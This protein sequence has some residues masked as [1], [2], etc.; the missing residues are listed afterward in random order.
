ML[1]P[2][3]LQV[4]AN[5]CV[6]R[7]ENATIYDGVADSLIAAYIDVREENASVNFTIAVHSHIR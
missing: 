4:K 7:Q 5:H 1:F 3:L 2:I 6:F